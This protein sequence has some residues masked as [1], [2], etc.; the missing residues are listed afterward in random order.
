[1]ESRESS[2]F[3]FLFKQHLPVA[4][5]PSCSI[6]VT[7][8]QV[9]AVDPAFGSLLP[10]G[11]PF[12]W[13]LAGANDGDSVDLR[14]I[15]PRSSKEREFVYISDVPESWCGINDSAS[16]ASL[17]LQYD[18]QTM[19]YLWLFLSYGGWRDCYTA[20]LE[21]CTNMPK[22]LGEATRAGQSA[23]LEPGGV[24]ETSVAVTLS[25]FRGAD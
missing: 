6:V 8:G 12:S 15:P 3:H 20:V 2:A 24:F 1:M 19:P 17:R 22:D 16:K 14:E 25:D 7:G 18:K 5:T 4:I 13:P 21:P 9:T 23:R 10:V 11:G